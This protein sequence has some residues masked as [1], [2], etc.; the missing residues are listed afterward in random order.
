MITMEKEATKPDNFIDG[1]ISLN[2]SITSFILKA[3]FKLLH[4]AKQF[5][6][7]IIGYSITS[8]IFLSI[9]ERLGFEQTIII[10]L[11]GVFWYG[12]RS[13]LSWPTK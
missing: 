13:G 7:I 10:L 1:W 9:Y 4:I 12:L 3:I 8:W 6:G 11:V 5:A 2:D